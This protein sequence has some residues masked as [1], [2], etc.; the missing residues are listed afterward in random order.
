MPGQPVPAKETPLEAVPQKVLLFSPRTIGVIAIIGGFPVGFA[1]SLAN[2]KRIGDRRAYLVMFGGWAAATLALVAAGLYVPIANLFLLVINLISAAAFYFIGKNIV[3]RYQQTGKV[4]APD[5]AMAA[6][7]LG[8]VAWV[9][10]FLVFSAL[11]AGTIYG[12]SQLGIR[13]P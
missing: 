12:L 11:L 13:L 4:Y 8:F 6:V 10:W 5:D 9:A 7:G 3:E 2:L 1:L